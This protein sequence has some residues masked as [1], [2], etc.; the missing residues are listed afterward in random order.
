MDGW[1]GIEENYHLHT[2]HH[3][4]APQPRS[5]P[6][7]ITTALEQPLALLLSL[8]IPSHEA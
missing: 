1:M 6:S 2:L 7:P 8:L 3:I 4:C 5:Q